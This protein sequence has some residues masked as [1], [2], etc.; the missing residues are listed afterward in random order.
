MRKFFF[1]LLAL[2][3]IFISFGSVAHAYVEIS[4]NQEQTTVIIHGKKEK[5]TSVSM[6]NGI[7]LCLEDE[8]GPTGFFTYEALRTAWKQERLT[9]QTPS[10]T[11][12]YF[13][14]GLE[15]GLFIV[16]WDK[17]TKKGI[18]IPIHFY[19]TFDKPDKNGD[20]WSRGSYD[21]VLD[22]KYWSTNGKNNY[23]KP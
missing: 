9:L 15:K 2:S 8:E 22:P 7:A 18:A 4:I 5:N 3:F 6:K 14:A 23:W 10:E 20:I 17:K 21:V 1:V 12:K 16:S 11:P 13:P 19:L